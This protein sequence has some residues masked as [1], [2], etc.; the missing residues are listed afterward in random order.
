MTVELIKIIMVEYNP[1]DFTTKRSIILF[2]S[3]VKCESY[4]TFIINSCNFLLLL[5]LIKGGQSVKEIFLE[6]LLCKWGC[7]CVIYEQCV[8]SE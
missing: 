5:L 3:L 6:I 2:R 1:D 7:L 8:R 4:Y